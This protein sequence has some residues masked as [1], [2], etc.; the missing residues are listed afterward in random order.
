M[1]GMIHINSLA[2]FMVFLSGRGKKTKIASII[3][4]VLV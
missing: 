1:F 4:L 3:L 2:F